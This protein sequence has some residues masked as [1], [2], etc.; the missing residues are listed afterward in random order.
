MQSEIT[1][2]TLALSGEYTDRNVYLPGKARELFSWSV[3]ILF[4]S[5][6][7][8]AASQKGPRGM[9]VMRWS[10]QKAIYPLF[11]LLR[12]FKKANSLKADRGR[13]RAKDGGGGQMRDIDLPRLLHQVDRAD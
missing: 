4:P 12:S 7:Y 8:S 11:V 13:G 1:R 5:L 6:F 2:H 9:A 10:T 3:L